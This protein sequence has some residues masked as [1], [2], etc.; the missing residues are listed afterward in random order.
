M[1]A[2]KLRIVPLGGLGEVG[3]N[4]MALEYA[5]DIIIIDAGFMFP[6]EEMPGIGMLIP[7]IDYLRQ[8]RAKLKGIIITHGHLD[9]IG[10]LPYILSD[11]PLPIYA[12]KFTKELINN[13]LKRGGSK[14]KANL[15]SGHPGNRITLGN[16][17]I[18]FF[19]VCHSIPDSMGLIIRTPIGV[20][21]HSGDFKLDQ[22]PILGTPTDLGRLAQLG[23]KGT[24]LL[25]SDSTYAELPGYTPSEQI[26]STTLDHIM[27]EAPGRI[28]I[29]T[30]S[31]LVSRIQQVINI[32]V[33]HN[34]R[35]FITSRSIESVVKAA[36][37]TGYLNI[38]DGSLCHL[39]E[40]KSLPHNRVVALTSGTQG[41]PTSAL[42]R[43][44]NREH[45][46][47]KILPGDTV[48]I[49]ATPI[50]G[51][52]TLISRTINSLFK[53]GAN[54]IYSK[55]AQVH[56]HGHGGQEEL[57]LLLN[58]VQPKF[59]IPI[60]GEYRHLSLHARLAR[61]LNMPE[62][63]IF[64][65]QDGDVLELGPEGGHVIDRIHMSEICINGSI[66]EK[67]DNAILRERKSLSRDGVVI[68][69]IIIDAKENKLL[70]KPIVENR[71]LISAEESRFLT[72]DIQKLVTN[73]VNNSGKKLSSE[74]QV[75]QSRQRNLESRI[76]DSLAKLLYEKTHRRPVIVPMIIEMQSPPSPTPSFQSKV[77]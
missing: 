50:P 26:V 55:L 6:R 62:N 24:L 27:A 61:S 75:A 10:A 4:M 3:M 46:Q 32:A 30:F 14:N 71:G 36:I 73:V 25:L 29:T 66:P 13:E 77:V 15:R 16:F 35:V 34:R 40:F 64:V 2:N 76:R 22:T 67:I 69:S 11:L 37:K 1:P 51:N 53:Q 52:E 33:N 42:V 7:D 54:V 31:S 65:L 5:D 48:V 23:A 58:L 19:R 56:V 20:I 49:S 63:N 43:I 59:F 41:E 17:A 28:I 74:K 18:D 72:E 21:V 44:A 60:H 68:V 70:E 47:I 57:K 8:R 9:H 45:K 39:D 12:T 38:P